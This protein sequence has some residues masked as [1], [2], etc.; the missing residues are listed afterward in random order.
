MP[1][2]NLFII[3]HGETEFNKLNIV[4]GSGV[5]TDLNETGLAQA[6]RFYEI[7]R[8]HPFEAV[9][10][11]ALKRSQQSV[12]GF[13]Q[14]GIPHVIMPEL[15]EIS[16][17][18]FE[19]KPQSMEQRALYWEMINQWN[20]GNLDAKISNGESPLQ[21]QERQRTA[22]ASMMAHPAKEILV[23]M[24]GRAMKS[25]LCLLLDVPLTRMEDFPHVNLC[26]YQV[27][28]QNGM[29]R[30]VKHN[31]TGHLVSG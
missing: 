6:G 5:D 24:H 15:N 13:L 16:W 17:G 19:G 21:M 26:L 18:D 22:L 29:F 14:S 3:R 27:E 23:C 10:T 31:D 25:F 20:A 1:S 12:A 8:Q 7:Y 4:Q 30:L 9:Y 28:Y 2:K 11:S